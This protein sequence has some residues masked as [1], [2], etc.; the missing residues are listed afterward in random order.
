M[1]LQIMKLLN[2]LGKNDFKIIKEALEYY[3]VDIVGQ[4]RNNINNSLA[5]DTD[6]FTHTTMKIEEYKRI[7]QLRDIM[8][9]LGEVD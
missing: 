4:V 5:T 8:K 6:D 2:N 3:K 9:E 1:Q 7:I